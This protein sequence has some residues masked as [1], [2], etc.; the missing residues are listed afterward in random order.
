MKKILKWFYK[1]EKQNFVDLPVVF[2]VVDNEWIEFSKQKPPHEVVLAACDTSDC[3]WIM[4]T[5]WWYE[6]KQCWMTTG[7]IENK[8]AHL[9]YTHWRK[10]PSFPK[11]NI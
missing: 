10:L 8:E 3:G 7:S 11:N 2:S 4:D 5:V 1:K 9:P 6:E